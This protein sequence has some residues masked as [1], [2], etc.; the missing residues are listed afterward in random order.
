M[1]KCYGCGEKH[2]SWQDMTLVLQNHG[3]QQ[4]AL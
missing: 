1:R 3:N 2:Y 4:E